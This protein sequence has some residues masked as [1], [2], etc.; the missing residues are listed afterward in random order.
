VQSLE[1]VAEFEPR[2]S[3][4]IHDFVPISLANGPGRRAVIWVQ[5]CTLGC[6]GCY[7]AELL[8]VAGGRLVP[9]RT[10]FDDI[11]ALS[12]DIQG[13]TVSGGEPFQQTEPLAALLRL[14]REQTGLS[15]VVFTG[16]TWSEVTA[17]PGGAALLSSID[18]L[19][20]GR[21]VAAQRLAHGLRGSANKTI[22]LLTNRF[23]HQD[24][25]AVPVAEVLIAR[26]GE[27]VATGIDPMAQD[28]RPEPVEL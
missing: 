5:G 3:L 27:T 25:E 8:P 20:A 26:D 19:I 10:L 13:I 2:E 23:T 18:V 14:V 24:L 7:N 12:G 17:M 21:Y 1:S 16:Y 6:P 28:V 9:I 22:H 11:V 15:V 4:W